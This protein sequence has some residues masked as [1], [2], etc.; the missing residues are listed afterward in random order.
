MVCGGKGNEELCYRYNYNNDTWSLWGRL[1]DP[2]YHQA[3][4]HTQSMGLV[5]AGGYDRYSSVTSST[6]DGI[7]FDNNTVPELPY[8]NYWH[9]MASTPDGTMFSL[10][11][12]DIDS[13]LM[14]RP[15]STEWEKLGGMANY[16]RSG[17]GCGY[18]S[19]GE[20]IIKIIFISLLISFQMLDH[21]LLWLGDTLKPSTHSCSICRT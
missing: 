17:I 16:A 9:C 5:I 2:N 14:L 6:F 20:F 7:N 12:Q 3:F 18:V 19:S 1:P 11:G 10:G 4:T 13:Y 8:G 15:N 21:S